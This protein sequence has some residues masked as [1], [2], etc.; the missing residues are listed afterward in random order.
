MAGDYSVI[1]KVIIPNRVTLPLAS[2]A[3]T[4]SGISRVYSK[5]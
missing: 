2:I 4:L 5:R 3:I 1:S